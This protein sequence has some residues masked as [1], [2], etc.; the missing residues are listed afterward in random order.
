MAVTPFAA[1][2]L[3]FQDISMSSIGSPL[4]A[5]AP[6]SLDFLNSQLVAHGFAHG[7][8]LNLTDMR[9]RD[10]QQLLKCLSN[11]LG[12]RVVSLHVTPLPERASTRFFNLKHV[13]NYCSS[14]RTIFLAQNN[15][16]QSTKHSPMNMSRCLLNTM[17]PR[18]WRLTLSANW[19]Q[20]KRN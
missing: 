13:A 4:S 6:D 5:A 7:N 14:Y 1:R 17:L 9:G 20:I 11:M 16:P 2:A 19:K 3:H 8:G 18:S 10:Q 15:L 12:Q